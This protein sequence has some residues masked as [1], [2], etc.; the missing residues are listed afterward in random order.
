MAFSSEMDLNCLDSFIR[1]A[2]RGG[3]REMAVQADSSLVET[4]IRNPNRVLGNLRT[5]RPTILYHLC[6]RPHPFSLPTSDKR[7]FLSRVMFLG[8]Y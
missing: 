2:K 1:R 4:I 3:F 7:D 5:L 8:L 6:P